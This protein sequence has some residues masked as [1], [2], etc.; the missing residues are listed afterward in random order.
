MIV[1][2]HW[3]RE[4]INFNL[5]LD[6]LGAKLYTKKACNTC[7]TLDGSALVGPSYLQT[8]QMWG[9]ERVFDDGSSTVIDDNYIRS[10]ILEPMTQIVAGYQGVMP[11]YQ[12]LLSDRE[13]DALIE[14]GFG[15]VE[16]TRVV[17]M[18]DAVAVSEHNCDIMQRKLMKQV[19]DHE[20]E[21]SVGNFFVWQRLLHEIAGISNYSEK[22][23]NRIRMLLTL[24]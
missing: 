8:S 2:I 14:S 6:E 3:L 11:T 23:A 19:L 7:H 22:L 20:D 4:H 21:L 12:G 16:A 18:V 17:Q 9:Q 15:G 13:L 1:S 24:K 5:P 10:S